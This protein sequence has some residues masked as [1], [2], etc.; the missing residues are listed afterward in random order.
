MCAAQAVRFDQTFADERQ[1]QGGPWYSFC[2][3]G[4]ELH[5]RLLRVPASA[6]KRRA[7]P[8]QGR[9]PPLRR[10]PRQGD[11]GPHPA[12]QAGA[13]AG[14]PGQGARPAQR[15]A[16][17]PGRQGGGTFPA[18]AV[19]LPAPPALEYKYGRHVAASCHHVQAV[20]LTCFA[21]TACTAPMS[22]Q[23]C[24]ETTGHHASPCGAA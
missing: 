9:V 20:S 11:R 8:E 13:R 6:L 18:P 17:P 2:K 21:T 24:E 15:G 23:G 22:T 14:R 16:R 3:N 5:G 1:V 7:W 19:S 12:Q 4:M 10:A